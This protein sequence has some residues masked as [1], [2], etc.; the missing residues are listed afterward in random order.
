MLE[1]LGTPL[2]VVTD[3][4]FVKYW[5]KELLNF[6]KVYFANFDKRL[7]RNKILQKSMAKYSKI[8]TTQTRKKMKKNKMAPLPVLDAVYGYMGSAITPL[9]LTISQDKR[10]DRRTLRCKNYIQRFVKISRF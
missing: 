1:Y 7:H 6:S 3:V 5:V 8:P 10:F 2:F 9:I 4:S